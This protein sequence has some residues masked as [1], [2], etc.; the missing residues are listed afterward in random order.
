MGDIVLSK[1]VHNV[2]FMWEPDCTSTDSLQKGFIHLLQVSHPLALG[3]CPSVLAPLLFQ[4]NL[5]DL[6]YF[7]FCECSRHTTQ[8]HVACWHKTSYALGVGVDVS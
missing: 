1:S 5:L 4:S 7:S 6:M 2:I 3:S 8:R